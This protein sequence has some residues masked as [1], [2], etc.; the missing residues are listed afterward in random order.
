MIGTVVQVS[1]AC[2]GQDVVTG[3]PQDGQ[4]GQLLPV[5]VARHLRWR[6]RASETAARS[7]Y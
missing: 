1:Q 6:E 7:L 5:G 4:L 3:D 2:Q